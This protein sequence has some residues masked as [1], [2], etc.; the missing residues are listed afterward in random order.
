M[1]TNLQHTFENVIQSYKSIETN[2]HNEL[3][4]MVVI[5]KLPSGSG[6]NPNSLQN[7]YNDSS[8]II[9]IKNDDHYCLIRS[10]VVAIE[11]L[12]NKASSQPKKSNYNP[13]SQRISNLE[14]VTKLRMKNKPCGIDDAQ[15]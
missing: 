10:V 2:A 5:A 9:T 7:F 8:N 13:A 6:Y 15:K 14:A 1:S 3:K 12:E 4:A 11:Y